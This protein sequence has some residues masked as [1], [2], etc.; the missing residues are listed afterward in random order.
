MSGKAVGRSVPPSALVG[1]DRG[2][3]VL[4]AGGAV[5]P[6]P[7]DRPFRSGRIGLLIN[8]WGSAPVAQ[9]SPLLC[10]GSGIASPA[11]VIPLGG[12][13]GGLLVPFG[14]PCLDRSALVR[15]VARLRRL[16]PVGLRRRET[17]RSWGAPCLACRGV[18]GFDGESGTPFSPLRGERASLPPV[19]RGALA[20]GPLDVPFKPQ[21]DP[22]FQ[23]ADVAL[24]LGCAIR[25][26]DRTDVGAGREWSAWLSRLSVTR[27]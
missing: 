13:C 2:R 3:R 5:A 14:S 10:R 4:F 19:K 25:R 11:A 22:L 27:S 12:W 6:R 1:G 26:R 7:P 15:P 9:S 21:E 20:H 18:G 16:R 17:A 23:A 8:L 24:P